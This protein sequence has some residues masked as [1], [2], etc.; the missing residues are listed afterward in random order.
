[1]IAQRAMLAAGLLP[2]AVEVSPPR[3]RSFELGDV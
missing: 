2:H 1:M 3:D